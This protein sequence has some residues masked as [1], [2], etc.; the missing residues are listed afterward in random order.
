[1]NIISNQQIYNAL[2]KFIKTNDCLKI[3]KVIP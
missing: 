1:M 2:F 3:K